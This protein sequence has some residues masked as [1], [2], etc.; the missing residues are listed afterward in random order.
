MTGTSANQA[1]ARRSLAEAQEAFAYE[2]T[3]EWVLSRRTRVGEAVDVDE[4]ALHL[5]VD[6]AHVEGALM[7]LR[8]E[9]FVERDAAG[10][11]LQ[12]VGMERA[13][14]LF[15]ARAAIQVG[16]VDGHLHELTHDL[17]ETLRGLAAELAEIVTEP[18]PG[19][20]RFLA[21]SHDYNATL[22]SLAGSIDLVRAYER[23]AIT[24][25]WR[26]SLADTDWWEIFDVEHHQLLTE[27]LWRRDGQAA[28]GHLLRHRE[29]VKSIVRQVFEAGGGAL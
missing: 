20:E 6:S 8:H 17:L 24:E 2:G 26:G 10:F 1:T 27:A 15:N 21:A 3:R 29:Q 28:K 16:V 19:F 22:I 14:A 12:P 9:A 23:M 5:D 11:T 18:M 4:L 7:R 25:L 13:M